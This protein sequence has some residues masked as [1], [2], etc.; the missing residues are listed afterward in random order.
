MTLQNLLSE[1]QSVRLH[2]LTECNIEA[3]DF[4]GRSIK[5]EQ[6]DAGLEQELE[7]AREECADLEKQIKASKEESDELTRQLEKTEAELE[8]DTGASE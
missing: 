4:N 6:T 8:A 3:V 5:L 7:E 1:L 2:P